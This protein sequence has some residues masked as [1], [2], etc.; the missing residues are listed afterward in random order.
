MDF[1][2]PHNRKKEGRKGGKEEKRRRKKDGRSNSDLSEDLG[3]SSHA[4][5]RPFE[6]G[7]SWGQAISLIE[8]S[9]KRTKT[10]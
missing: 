9:S 5:M 2:Q 7:S 6:N 3:I 8:I 1:K 4:R 10:M